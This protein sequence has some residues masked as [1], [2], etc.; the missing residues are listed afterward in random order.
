[1]LPPHTRFFNLRY[2]FIDFSVPNFTW[3]FE[4]VLRNL[5]SQNSFFVQNNYLN[6][7][8]CFEFTMIIIHYKFYQSLKEALLWFKFL[9]FIW[10]FF[11]ILDQKYCL[12]IKNLKYCSFKTIFRQHNIH[13]V[14]STCQN[15]YKLILCTE[16][17]VLNASF[18]DFWC[19]NIDNHLI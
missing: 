4:F 15:K 11:I 8:V 3:L 18:H 12:Y 17:P 2:L 16:K 6:L 9:S 14:F 7:C 1:M 5:K 10:Y 19:T 13:L